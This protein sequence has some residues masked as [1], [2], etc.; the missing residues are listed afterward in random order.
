MRNA[1]RHHSHIAVLPAI[2]LA[3]L[4]IFGCS[5]KSTLEEE[6]QASVTVTASPATIDVGNTSVV[7]ATV[8]VNGTPQADQVVTFTVSPP[9]A[10]YFTPTIDTTDT[11]GVAASIF[12]ATASGSAQVSASTG[13]GPSV[14][15]ASMT[16]TGAQTGSGSVSITVSPSLILA[17]GTDTSVVTVT[18]RDQSGQPAPDSTMI[19][20]T[21]GEKFEDVDGNGYWTDGVDSLVFDANS[22]GY[23]D[24]FGLI[25]SAAQVSGGAGQAVVNYIAGS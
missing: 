20:L 24:A 5:S 13:S 9:S 7:E 25:P 6:T 22:N 19:K 11:D 12:T 15:S 8:T 2:S 18:V 21:A 1:I 10:G 14:G 16:I 4:T 23:W 3:L 17:N